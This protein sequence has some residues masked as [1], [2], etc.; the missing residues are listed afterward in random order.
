MIYKNYNLKTWLSKWHII[1]SFLTCFYII[2]SFKKKVIL[3][4]KSYFYFKFYIDLHQMEVFQ[5]FSWSM[6]HPVCMSG[7]LFLY[8]RG[9]WVG[10][11]V[12]PCSCNNKVFP[13]IHCGLSWCLSQ[14]WTNRNKD[15]KIWTNKNQ[16]FGQI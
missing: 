11:S 13:H 12:N 16:G 15:V 9:H 7:F 2:I 5:T 3:I 8:I 14:L 4:L 1:I 6:L 10:T